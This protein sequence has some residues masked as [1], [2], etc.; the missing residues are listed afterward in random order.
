V[1]GDALPGAADAV[2]AAARAWI[3][4]D[5]DAE[6]RGELEAL[7]ARASAGDADAAAELHARFDER[8]AFGTAGL[9]GAIAAGPNRMNRVLVTQAA[10]GLAQYLLERRGGGASVVIGYDGRKNSR[11]FAEDSAEIFAGAGV[12]TVLLPRLLPTPVLAFAVRH[13]GVSAGVMVTASHNPG[14][15]NGYKVYLGDDDQG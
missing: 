11:I 1:S 12:R 7:V 4:Q 6:T 10:A 5:P 3:A 13:L 14:T 15:D 2:I 9:R 8:L